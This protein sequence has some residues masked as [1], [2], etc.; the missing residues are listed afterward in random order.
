MQSPCAGAALDP[1]LW[2]I[3]PNKVALSHTH[4]LSLSPA[5]QVACT[6]ALLPVTVTVTAC[7]CVYY[8]VCVFITAVPITWDP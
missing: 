2:T 1:P 4:T 3:V 8:C 6:E 7:V 5:A